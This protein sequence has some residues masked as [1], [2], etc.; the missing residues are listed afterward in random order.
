M[1]SRISKE[2]M[3]KGLE[4]LK[5]ISETDYAKVKSLAAINEKLFKCPRGLR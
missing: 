1:M 5:T 4:Q 3:G 2:R